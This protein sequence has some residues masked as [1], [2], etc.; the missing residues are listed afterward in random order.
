LQIA[1]CLD[2]EGTGF[3]G[4]GFHSGFCFF[5]IFFFPLDAK[6]VGTQKR[7]MKGEKKKRD[8]FTK[9]DTGDCVC[10]ISQFFKTPAGIF[11]HYIYYKHIP[12][13]SMC[14]DFFL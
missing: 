4:L 13:Q 8:F 11:L 1:L 9:S 12:M 14:R 7:K 3:F 5:F 6:T 2:A 10:T